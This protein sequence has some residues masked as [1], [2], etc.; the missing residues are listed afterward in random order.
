LP[1]KGNAIPAENFPEPQSIYHPETLIFAMVATGC[2]K[3]GGKSRQNLPI[4]HGFKLQMF[5]QK[6][7]PSG[8]FNAH[9][10][11]TFGAF[12]ML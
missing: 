8:G 3:N 1:E 7:K 11:I 2:A 5:V 6:C 4:I 10:H 9:K 12:F